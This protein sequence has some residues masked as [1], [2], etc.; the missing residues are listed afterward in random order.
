MHSGELPRFW[1]AA[2]AVE[3]RM[4]AAPR[5]APCVR[6]VLSTDDADVVKL[7]RALV[8]EGAWLSNV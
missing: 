4:L 1:E 7:A 6:W 3:A 2:K 8:G 5:A